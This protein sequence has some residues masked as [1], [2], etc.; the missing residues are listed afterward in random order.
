ME[1][2]SLFVVFVTDTIIAVCACLV[3]DRVL[4]LHTCFPMHGSYMDG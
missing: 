3:A 1:Q 2:R 4:I